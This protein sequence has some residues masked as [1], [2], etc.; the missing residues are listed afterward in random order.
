[1]PARS[2]C[3]VDPRWKTSLQSKVVLIEQGSKNNETYKPEKIC[4]AQ[5]QPRVLISNIL[6]HKIST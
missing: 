2:I 4:L 1:M 3:D 5:D 6:I